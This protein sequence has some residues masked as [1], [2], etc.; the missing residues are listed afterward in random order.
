[1][2][3]RSFFKLFVLLGLGCVLVLASGSRATTL[4]VSTKPVLAGQHDHA[5]HNAVVSESLASER[6]VEKQDEP[7]QEGPKG[8]KGDRDSYVW[9]HKCP[10]LEALFPETTDDKLREMETRLKSKSFFNSSVTRMSKAIQVDTTVSDKMK[11]I[12]PEDEAWN[13]MSK[14][15]DF[16]RVTFPLVHTTLQLQKINTHG[17]LFTWKGTD[18]ALKPTIIMAHQD[19][20]GVE[21]GDDLPWTYPPF[22]GHWDGKYIWGRGATDCKNTLIASLEAVEELV[23]AGWQPKRTVILSYGFD[24]EIDGHHGSEHIVKHLLETYGENSVAVVIDEGPGIAQTWSGTGGNTAFVGVGEKGY[25]DVEITVQMPTGHSSLPPQDN[26]ITVMAELVHELHKNQYNFS[27]TDDNPVT[28]MVYCVAQYDE[29]IS[30]VHLDVI[31]Q[32]DKG[33]LPFDIIAQGMINMQPRMEGMFRTTQSIGMI[34]GGR[35][36][37]VVPGVTSVLINHRVGQTF[38]VF[39]VF[40]TASTLIIC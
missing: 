15:A 12:D 27:V 14:F 33:E 5:G 2:E 34:Q 1:M 18:P 36:V 10:Q 39:T 21:S 24:E 35:K 37:N 11:L 22:S 7:K 23:R 13:S 3:V 6:D 31:K 20:V 28:A 19:V 38:L 8:P 4:A 30:D 9:N 29:G 16:L 25:L 26:S 32:V 40:A 17:L